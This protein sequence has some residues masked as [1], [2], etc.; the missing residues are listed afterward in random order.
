MYKIFIYFLL[1]ENTKGLIH[2]IAGRKR[3][4]AFV[5]WVSIVLQTAYC[6]IIVD[7]YCTEYVTMQLYSILYGSPWRC[8]KVAYLDIF[9]ENSYMSCISTIVN[10]Y[11]L[12]ILKIGFCLRDFVIKNTTG[13]YL[14]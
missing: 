10:K 12:V 3:H 14:Y 2:I 7:L 6:N 5:D 11:R 1:S 8:L 4:A 13:L 9:M